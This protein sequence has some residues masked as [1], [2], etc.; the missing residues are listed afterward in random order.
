MSTNLLLVMSFTTYRNNHFMKKKDF[1]LFYIFLILYVFNL[2]PYAFYIFY[3]FLHIYFVDKLNYFIMKVSS[4]RFYHRI[5]AKE[6]I[7]TC[8]DARMIDRTAKLLYQ[9]AKNAYCT[10]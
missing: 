8:E 4:I 10:T 9:L 2:F 5:I 3:I 7:N 1:S 6:R